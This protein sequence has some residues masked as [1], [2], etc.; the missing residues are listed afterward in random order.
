MLSLGCT[1]KGGGAAP[2]AAAKEAAQSPQAAEKNPEE[3]P[4]LVLATT[5][6]TYNS[7]LLEVLNTEFQKK[8]GVLVEVHA[9]GTGAALRMGKDGEVDVVL[10]HARSKEDKFLEEGYG[11]NRRNVM[12]NDFVIVGPKSDPAGI[13]GMKSAAE[14]FAKIAQA[15]AKFLSRGDNSGTHTKELSIWKLAGITPSGEWYEQTGQGMGKTLTIA[16]EKQGYTLTD[17]G[18]YLAYKGKLDLEILVEGPVKGGDPL[19]ANPYAVIAVNPKKYPE[20]NYELAMLYIGFLTSPEGQK[21]IAEFKKN[22]EQLFYPDALVDR[23]NYNQYLPVTIHGLY[24]EQ[25]EPY[26]GVTLPPKG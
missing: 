5:T 21:L 13:R 9:V 17:R 14:A 22:G 16:N 7:G 10:V 20:R 8:Y 2:E 18:T 25:G 19:L 1:A 23:E 6:S 3:M 12:Y 11:I 4:K 26:T 15:K 24:N